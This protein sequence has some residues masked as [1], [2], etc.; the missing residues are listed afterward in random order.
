MVHPNYPEKKMKTDGAY[1]KE[2]IPEKISD[3]GKTVERV[4]VVFDV[5]KEVSLK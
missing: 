1:G 3:I 2:Q 4:G 5:S